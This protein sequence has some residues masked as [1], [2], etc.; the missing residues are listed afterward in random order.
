MCGP[1]IVKLSI[2]PWLSADRLFSNVSLVEFIK[3]PTWFRRHRFNIINMSCWNF[4]EKK[5]KK[6][7]LLLFIIL[8]LQNM[9]Y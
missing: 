9:G 1:F 5:S 6:Y 7:I 3:I 8:E 2:K 4:N